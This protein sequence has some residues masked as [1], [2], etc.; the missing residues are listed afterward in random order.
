MADNNGRCNYRAIIF[1]FLFIFVLFFFFIIIK[2]RTYLPTFR[3]HEPTDKIFKTDA[4]YGN[5]NESAR[6]NRSRERYSF[7]AAAVAVN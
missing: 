1:S 3:L 7:P 5:I 4:K 2:P 6:K